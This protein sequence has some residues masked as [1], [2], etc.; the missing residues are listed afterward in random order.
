MT[1]LFYN[2]LTVARMRGMHYHIQLFSVEAQVGFNSLVIS[3]S[4]ICW[5]ARHMPLCTSPGWN[6]ISW[7]PCLGWPQTSILPI[8]VF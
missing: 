8:L 6:G 3:V 2:F 1:L 4:H 5:D 7:T